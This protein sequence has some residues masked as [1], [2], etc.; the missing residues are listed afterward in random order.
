[1]LLALDRSPLERAAFLPHDVFDTPFAEIARV[2][3]TRQD[4]TESFGSDS[5]R[6]KAQTVQTFT[7]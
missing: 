7:R 3:K 4:K 2:T 1:L 6:T 5:T